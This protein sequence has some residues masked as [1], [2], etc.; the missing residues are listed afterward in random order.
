MGIIIRILLIAA[1]IAIV[2][3]LIKRARVAASTQTARRPKPGPHA[4]VACAHCGVHLPQGDA[5]EGEGGLHYCGAEHRLLGPR[6]R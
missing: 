3:S 6:P 5:L 1:V 4:M 2:W